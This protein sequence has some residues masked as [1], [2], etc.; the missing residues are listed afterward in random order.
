MVTAA[1]GMTAPF[2]SV[3]LPVI[4]P[5]NSW[6]AANTQINS[7]SAATQLMRIKLKRISIDPFAIAARLGDR[8]KLFSGKLIRDRDHK[9]GLTTRDLLPRRLPDRQRSSWGFVRFM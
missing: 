7:I 1:P 8:A 6:P 9:S 5:R 3:T 4:E 2:G